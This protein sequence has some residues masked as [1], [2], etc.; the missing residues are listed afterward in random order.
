[1]IGRT[2]AGKSTLI[3]AITRMNEIDAGEITIGSRNIGELSLRALRKRIA[4]IPQDPVLFTGTIRSNLDPFGAAPGDHALWAALE[5]SYPCLVHEQGDE[6]GITGYFLLW[7]ARG[8][9]AR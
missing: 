1:M 6:L 7:F 2:G 3:N 4:I 8:G 9:F 5:Q